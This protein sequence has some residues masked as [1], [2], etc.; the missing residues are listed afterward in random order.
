MLRPS[1]S[2]IEYN[3]RMGSQVNSQEPPEEKDWP[4]SSLTIVG[5]GLIGGSLA[6]A[7]RSAGFTGKITG[8]SRPASLEQA[9][10]LGAITG[11]EPYERLA[12]AA[13]DA[14]LVV[15]SSP[16]ETILKHLEQLGAAGERLLPGTVITDVGSTKRVILEAA[17]KRLPSHVTFIGGHP[18]AGSEARGIGAADPFLF[19]NA[20]YVLTPAPAVPAGETERLGSFLGRLGARVI[21]LDAA[22]HDRIAAT[23]SHLPQAL[24]VSLVRFLESLGPNRD[25]GVHLAAGG[26]RDMTRI[27]SSPYGV[28][29]DIVATNHDLIR[30]ILDNFLRHTRS[31]IGSLEDDVLEENFEKAALTRG[32]I[33]RDTKGFLSRLWNV[34]VVV[35]DRP[36]MIASIATP[37]ADSGINIKDIE[38][39][40]VREGEGGSLRL[41]F[42]SRE[43]AQ[44]AVD[45][46][47]ARGFEARLQD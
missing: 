35:E 34:L 7:L 31:T 26:F 46:L 15:L 18:M 28:W 23:I 39:L 40:K 6:L 43:L 44:G 20:Y 13:A 10:R 32:E 30:E 45:M 24:A 47:R 16:I 38:V 9:A 5:L 42:A 25:D 21:V 36:G 3:A 4:Y 22:A 1:G 2:L 17:R 27:A 33:P 37:L 8:V 12:E 11:G 19:Q 41:A 29:R 14:D